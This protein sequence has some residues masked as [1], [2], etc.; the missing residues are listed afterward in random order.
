ME[1]LK[2]LD[3]AVSRKRPEIWS[4]DWIL[5]HDSASNHKAISVKHFLAQKE[6]TKMEHPPHS[7][8]LAPS[9]FRPFPKNKT[10]LQGTKIS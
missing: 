9:V 3:E 6:I 4:S 10:C 5:H 8:D 7:P 1:I 2:W